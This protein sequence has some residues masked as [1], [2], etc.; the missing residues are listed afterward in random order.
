MPWAIISRYSVAYLAV[1]SPI[2]RE[3]PIQGA[4][5]AEKSTFRIRPAEPKSQ[6]NRKN[7]RAVVFA[8][9]CSLV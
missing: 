9:G 1:R 2:F 4:D 8:A 3:E 7:G 6:G 5:G